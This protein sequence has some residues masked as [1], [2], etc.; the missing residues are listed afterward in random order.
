MNSQAGG[1]PNASTRARTT[2]TPTAT[3]LRSTQRRNR[4]GWPR[5]RAT[6]CHPAYVVRNAVSD[7]PPTIWSQCA[8][9]SGGLG[10]IAT[11]TIPSTAM[12]NPAA[13]HG[14]PGRCAGGLGADGA[15]GSVTRVG[16]PPATP[17][18]DRAGS[19]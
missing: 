6:S 13:R 7:A 3:R 19:S 11:S 2:P 14:P 12:T 18:Y 8:T 16:P 1:T 17:L 10:V 15:S 4:L 9:L 5:S